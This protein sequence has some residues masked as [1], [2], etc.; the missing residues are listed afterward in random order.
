MQR[1]RVTWLRDGDANTKFFHQSTLQRRRRNK[2]LKI[3][4]E[5]GHWVENPCR[6]RQLVDDH[7][8]Q[9]FSSGG[10]LNWGELLDCIRPC[11]T[12]EMNESLLQP[13][14]EVEIKDAALKIGGLKAPGPDGFQGIFYQSFWDSVRVDV[15]NLVNVFMQGSLSPRSLNETHIV[16]IPKVPHPEVV[17]Q[18]R[19]ISLCNYFYKILSKVLAGQ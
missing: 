5:E 18:F 2:V 17:T 11:V 6:V 4:D 14:S 19:P 15:V 13:V 1:S 8:I 16:L 12:A 3:K 10:S 9:I 7:F